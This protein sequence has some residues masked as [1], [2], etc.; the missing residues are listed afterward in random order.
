MYELLRESLSTRHSDGSA[1][2]IPL[3]ILKIAGGFRQM[4]FAHSTHETQSSIS[5]SVPFS[6]ADK[7]V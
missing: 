4:M 6:R 1:H 5:V 2:E 3:E 7:N